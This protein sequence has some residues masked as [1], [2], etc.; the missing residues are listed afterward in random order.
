MGL[1]EADD[2]NPSILMNLLIKRSLFSLLL[3]AMT[4]PATPARAQASLI[5]EA[6]REYAAGNYSSAKTK[7]ELVLAAD[8]KNVVAKNYLKMIAAAESQAGPGAK[9]EAQLKKLIL[10]QVEIREA[11]L[12]SALEYLRQ[13]AA[14]ASGDKLKPSFVLQPGVNSAAPV[15]LRLSNIPFTE[16]LRY[17]GE[18]AAVQFSI[19]QYAISVRPKAASVPAAAPVE[20]RA[21]ETP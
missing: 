3:A 8:P 14:K 19:D 13:Q 11:T 10:P 17:V 16:A 2:F 9:T 12:D 7:F 4:L 15:T 18:L 5:T 6:Q 1:A 21:A 20:V